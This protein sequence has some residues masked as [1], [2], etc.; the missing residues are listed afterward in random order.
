M[1]ERLLKKPFAIINILF[2]LNFA[3]TM[4]TLEKGFSVGPR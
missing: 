1:E 2:V 3:T 4:K